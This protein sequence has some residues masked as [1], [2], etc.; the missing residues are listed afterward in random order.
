[1]IKIKDNTIKSGYNWFWVKNEYHYIEY[2]FKTNSNC[3]KY[4]IKYII[5]NFLK[6]EGYLINFENIVWFGNEEIIYYDFDDRYSIEIYSKS[7]NEFILYF[8]IKEFDNFDN[9]FELLILQYYYN[10][11]TKRINTEILGDKENE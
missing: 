4:D 10:Q 2:E 6:E 3:S 11:I 9:L 1:M 7:E 8:V 5:D